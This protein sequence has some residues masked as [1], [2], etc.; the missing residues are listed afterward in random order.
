MRNTEA[1]NRVKGAIPHSAIPIRCLCARDKNVAGCCAE[2][3]RT[4]SPPA[5]NHDPVAPTDSAVRPPTT[6][7]NT[8]TPRMA[9]ITVSE[10]RLGIG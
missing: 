3:C 8:P 1:Q 10:T 7:A 2:D 5:F 6:D 9:A 4:T